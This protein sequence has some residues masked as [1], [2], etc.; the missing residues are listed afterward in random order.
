MSAWPSCAGLLVACVAGLPAA[1][2]DGWSQYTAGQYSEAVATWT[3]QATQ[4]DAD[5]DFGL[6]LAYDLGRGVPQD[7]GRACG[8]YRRAGD[9]GLAAAAFSYAVMLDGGRCGTRDAAAA[10]DWYGRASAAGHA[11]AEYGLAQLYERGDGVPQ[12]PDLAA[13]WY[14]LAAAA[15]VSVAATR[16][17]ALATSRDEQDTPLQS[18]TPVWPAGSNLPDHGSFVPFVWSAPAEPT[19]VRFFLEVYAL[20]SSGASEVAAR[21]VDV[22]ATDIA[23]APGAGDYAWRVFTVAPKPRSYVASPW[24]RF[25][26]A[27]RGAP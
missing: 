12:N 24:Q 6:G 23:L 11:R 19:A 9:S 26:V 2:P 21:Y 3:V 17:E 25:S 13:A 7:S 22:S 20:Q 18:A 4:G 1:A 15:G 10:A 14:R 5:G 16:A 27:A 8:Y